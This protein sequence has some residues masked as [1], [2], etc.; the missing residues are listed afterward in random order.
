MLEGANHLSCGIEVTSGLYTVGACEESVV[1]RAF[2]AQAQAYDAMKESV[3]WR[4]PNSKGG[5]DRQR[6]TVNAM[7]STA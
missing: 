3:A 7:L 4:V 2:K 5:I 1:V 6:Y